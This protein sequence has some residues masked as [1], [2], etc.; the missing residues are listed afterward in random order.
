M[1]FARAF[2]AGGVA[3][4]LALSAFTQTES[5]V[6]LKFSRLDLTDGRKLKN[7]VVK[8]YDAKTEK[9]LVVADGKA[10]TI[11]IAVVPAPFNQQ[12]KAAPASGGSVSTSPVLA[13]AADQYR[14]EVPAAVRPTVTLP[15][16]PTPPR[17]RPATDPAAIEAA[18]LKRH[19]SVA[20]TRAERY[21]R[22]EHPFGSS[23]I[24]VIGLEFELGVP[25]AVPGY[26][27]RVETNGKVWLEFYESTGGG[28]IQRATATFEITTEETPS[29][30]INVIEFRRKS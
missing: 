24:K 20:R 25:K 17:A 22:Y 2:I 7:V 8:S 6:P 13:T 4:L 29:D 26:S 10:M 19:Q 11:P 9:L 27:N 16:Q 18:R 1:T 14:M 30:G 23:S 3:V 28:S 5:D 21:Y 15:Q 12:L